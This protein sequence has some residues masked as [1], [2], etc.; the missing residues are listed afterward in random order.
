MNECGALVERRYSQGTVAACVDN[1]PHCHSAN[2][3]SHNDWPVLNPDLLV[4]SRA[5]ILYSRGTVLLRLSNLR[6]FIVCYDWPSLRFYSADN[7]QI[8]RQLLQKLPHS[9]VSPPPIDI[10]RSYMKQHPL[11]TEHPVS[12][13]EQLLTHWGRVRQI[14]VFTLQLCK[15][16]DANL[17]F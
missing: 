7:S 10:I 9:H 1:L 4:N 15:T 6:W 2:Q 16:D 13:V 17:R 12:L 3:R 14:C 8:P 5:P 11:V